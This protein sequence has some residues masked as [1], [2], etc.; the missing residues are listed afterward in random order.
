MGRVHA[1]EE[2]IPAR[3]REGYW[4]RM[5]SN[6]SRHPLRIPEMR[7][8]YDE[9]KPEVKRLIGAEFP[10]PRLG[11]HP[12]LESPGQSTIHVGAKKSSLTLRS[13]HDLGIIST[14]PHELGHVDQFHNSELYRLWHRAGEKR[15]DDL[16]ARSWL[17]TEGWADYVAL[18]YAGERD[19]RLGTCYEPT[20]TE[21]RKNYGKYATAT[22]RSLFMHIERKR[23]R[24]EARWAAMHFIDDGSLVNYIRK[25]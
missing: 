17:L 23:G 4:K 2:A 11:F 6:F 3:G 24:D 9:I 13:R 18:L 16:M 5:W 10:D 12:R 8:L 25:L 20:F 1:W 15:R 14:I 7:E 19:R 21:R 22:G